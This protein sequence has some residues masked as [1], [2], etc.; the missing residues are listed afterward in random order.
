VK[1]LA[2]ESRDRKR[3]WPAFFAGR[4]CVQ[5]ASAMSGLRF[6]RPRFPGLDSA[7]STRGTISATPRTDDVV[8]RVISAMPESSLLDLARSRAHADRVQPCAAP[9]LPRFGS[10][11]PR[12]TPSAPGGLKRPCSVQ[13]RLEGLPPWV[14]G[15]QTV[16]TQQPSASSTHPVFARSSSY[17]CGPDRDPISSP[18]PNVQRSSL[19]QPSGT[20]AV[21]PTSRGIDQA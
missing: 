6:E 2:L 10:T 11:W 20:T 16:A 3:M 12:A 4:C 21:D 9:L 14:S 5:R 13:D 1:T 8:A 19:A 15:L 18:T 7:A 17:P